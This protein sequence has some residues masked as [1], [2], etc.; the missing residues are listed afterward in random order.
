LNAEELKGNAHRA[1]D[2]I[3]NGWPVSMLEE[4]I[5]MIG[6]TLREALSKVDRED[7]TS[8]VEMHSEDIDVDSDRDYMSDVRESLLKLEAAC[9]EAVG[10]DEVMVHWILD[11]VVADVRRNMLALAKTNPKIRNLS[12]MIAKRDMLDRLLDMADDNGM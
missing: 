8:F 4:L 9:D 11:D 2:A 7:M 5:A 1:L 6:D 3:E 12:L 10:L